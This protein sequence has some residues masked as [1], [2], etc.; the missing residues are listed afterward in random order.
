MKKLTVI[1]MFLSLPVVGQAS[2]VV[3]F[4]DYAKAA[5]FVEEESCGTPKFAPH[6]LE[7]MQ[8]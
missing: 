6:E 5:I 4:S 1:F 2:T 7:A 8:K 3:D